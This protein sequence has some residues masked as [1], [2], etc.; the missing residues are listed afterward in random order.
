[1]AC[2]MAARFS[3]SSTVRPSYNGASNHVD[4]TLRQSI[5]SEGPYRSHGPYSWPNQPS[6]FTFQPLDIIHIGW[7]KLP[8]RKRSATDRVS[9]PGF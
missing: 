7:T 5:R 4:S 6:Q 3:H 9:L 8:W 2:F 1:M